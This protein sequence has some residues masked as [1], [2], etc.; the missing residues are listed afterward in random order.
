MVEITDVSILDVL[1]DFK[2][3]SIHAKPENTVFE[4]SQ[5]KVLTV[6]FDDPESISVRLTPITK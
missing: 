3:L 6:N 5:N 2:Q 4:S 1:N